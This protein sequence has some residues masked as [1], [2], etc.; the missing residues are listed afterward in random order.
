[1][2][3]EAPLADDTVLRLLERAR[4]GDASARE[5]L[6]ERLRAD[7]GRWASG[8]YPRWARDVADTSDL[9]QETL[10]E[11]FKNLDGFVPRG[12]GALQGS[13]R[14]AFR[15]RLIN[16]LRRAV[17]RP[18]HV[19]MESGMPDTATSP[20]E[21][22]IASET[23]ERYEAA[24]ARL[25]QD[26]RDAIIARIEFRLPYAE[27]AERL[28][29]SSADAARMAVVRALVKLAREM[30]VAE[31]TGATADTERPRQ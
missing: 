16:Q 5:D 11:T 23:L 6:F 7:L 9:V 20:L 29:K 1:M 10:V 25:S 13:V 30:G 12:V 18:A 21:A 8:R 26:E 15:N 31:S 4:G 3:D 28:G 17:K 24:L 14:Q 27:A 2:S 19:E 22:A